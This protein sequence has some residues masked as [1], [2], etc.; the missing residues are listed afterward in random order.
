MATIA[1][2]ATVQSEGDG[3]VTRTMTYYNLN[4]IISISLMTMLMPDWKERKLYL[5]KNVMF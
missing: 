2:F 4:I 3:Y 5:D 1:Y